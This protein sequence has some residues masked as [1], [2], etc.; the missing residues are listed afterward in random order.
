MN[1][2]ALHKQEMEYNEIVKNYKERLDKADKNIK[3][4]KSKINTIVITRLLIF[5]ATVSICY[6]YN[7]NI[8]IS[9]FCGIIGGIIFVYLIKVHSDFKDKKLYYKNKL[10]INKTEL[11]VLSGKTENLPNGDEF[12][13]SNHDFSYDIDLFGEGSFFQY[14]NRTCTLGG[15]IEL[16]KLL[17]GNS[18]K[19]INKKQEAIKELSPD[20]E[21]RQHFMAK[22]YSINDNKNFEYAIKWMKDYKSY[23]PKILNPILILFPFVSIILIILMSLDILPIAVF[24]IWFFVGLLIT[25][26]YMSN[27]NNVYQNANKTVDVINKYSDLLKSIEEK[28]FNSFLNKQMRDIINTKN[29]SAS[30]ILKKLGIILN[31]LNS[32]NN[33]IVII[34]G[35]ALFLWE[36]NAVLALDKWLNKYRKV[37]PNWFNSIYYF[38]ST[39]SCSNY[40]YNNNS[41]VFPTIS[42]TDITIRAKKMGHPLIDK[43]K[44]IN[45][46]IIIKNNN[47]IIITGANMAGKSTFL[48]T[49]SLN[50][51]L[52]NAGLPV[53]ADYF[54]YKPIKII[55][56]MRTSDSLKDDESYFFSELKRLKFISE[57]I[58]QE[59]Y[60]IMLDEI[61][62]GT[63]SKDKE[64][65]SKQFV[66]KLVSSGSTG[67]I[68]THDLALC[69]I[70][71]DFSQVLNFYFDAEIID[72][73]LHFDYKLKDGI[74]KNMNASFLLKKMNII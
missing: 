49:I 48:R 57:K 4:I 73:E 1:I 47:F 45:N 65:G 24:I 72:N 23:I 7:Y 60:F 52:A 64:I 17:T 21:W 9:I 16:K 53:C 58:K 11:D 12:K 39:I 5:V 43:N 70:E 63:N 30:K 14:I 62:K 71:N 37:V 25:A 6:F 28:E 31:R 13:D 42:D 51:V 3:Q 67:I 20:I 61:L 10:K 50:I 15:K 34:F 59:T 8:L 38:D 26:K 35:N 55:T 44:R 68:A 33:L 69:S 46:D 22:S 29:Y 27:T 19:N 40:S 74:C 41:Y 32:R 56:S 36:L 54:E 66:K 2:I 18:I